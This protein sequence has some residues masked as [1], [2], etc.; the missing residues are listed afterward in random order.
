MHLL[1]VVTVFEALGHKSSV[2][3][4]S[5]GRGVN[6]ENQKCGQECGG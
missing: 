3:P 6:A 5:T 2:V 1:G 4:D